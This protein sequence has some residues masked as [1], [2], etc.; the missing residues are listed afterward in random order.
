MKYNMKYNHN[1]ALSSAGC[2]IIIAGAVI[3]NVIICTNN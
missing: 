1:L 3:F 2:G